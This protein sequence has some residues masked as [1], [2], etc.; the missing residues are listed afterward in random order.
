MNRHHLHGLRIYAQS[1]AVLMAL[2]TSQYAY[3][4]TKGLSQIVTPDLQANGDFSLSFQ[5]QERSIGNPY[6]LQTELGITKWLE[7]AISQGLSPGEQIFGSEL[8]LIQHDPYLL[9]TGFIN[10]TTRHQSPQPFLEAGYYTE[11]DKFMG[12]P[13]QVHGQTEAIL[14]WAHDFDPMWRFQIDYQS[15]TEN[16]LTFGYTCN[17]TP[18]FQYNPAIY[19]SNDSAHR[20]SGYIVF[21]YTFSLWHD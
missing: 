13:I 18:N 7:V 11:H 4:T 15:G 14:G 6:Q 20:A 10:W 9:T 12:G 19:F 3:A 8:A 21:T 5:A 17:V 16:F 2:M 1:I